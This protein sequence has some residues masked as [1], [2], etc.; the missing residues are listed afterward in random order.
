ML[1]RD[2]DE[3]IALFADDPT[4]NQVSLEELQKNPFKLLVPGNARDGDITTVDSAE[5]ER[6]ERLAQLNSEFEQLNLQ[7]V[8]RGDPSL[9]VINNTV[10][11][12]N[13]TIGSFTVTSIDAEGVQ[14]TAEDETYTLRLVQ[15]DD[16]RVNIR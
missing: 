5:R 10:V 8:L 2:T 9:A 13:E 15:P 3:V 16:G 14:L 7:T 11:Q 1:F 6:L 4:H 12:L